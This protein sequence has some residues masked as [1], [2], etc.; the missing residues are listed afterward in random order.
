MNISHAL[1]RGSFRD[2]SSILAGSQNNA[3]SMEQEAIHYRRLNEE[4]L[5]GLQEARKLD[6]F[7]DFFRPK[8]IA[9]LTATATNGPVVILLVNESQCDALVLKQPGSV[10]HIPLPSFEFGNTQPLVRMLRQGLNA[11]FQQDGD[12]R[13]MKNFRQERTDGEDTF[14]A[15]L[16]VMWKS[17]AKPNFDLLHSQV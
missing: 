9:K 11:R 17:V 1:E 4:R 12:I 16:A 15:H 2:T 10:E 8:P 14:W 6:G 7:E 13:H 5:S 3:M